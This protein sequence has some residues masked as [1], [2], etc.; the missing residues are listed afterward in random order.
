MR[1]ASSS[2]DQS[3]P[4]STSKCSRS[5]ATPGSPIRSLTR[6]RG[7]P[8]RRGSLTPASARRRGGAQSAPPP[9]PAPA[10]GAAG[11]GGGGGGEPSPPPPPGGGGGGGRARGG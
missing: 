4:R 11:G 9:P 6:T 2:P 5:S 7:R 1:S 8:L 3:M 10:R